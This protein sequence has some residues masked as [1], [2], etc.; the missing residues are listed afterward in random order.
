MTQISI[1]SEPVPM[2]LELGTAL[3]LGDSELFELCSRN[4]AL[5]IERTARG[6]LVVMTPAGGESS[7]RNARIVA[8]LVTWADADGS[9]VVYDSSAGFLLSDGSMRS[10]DA[11]WVRRGRLDKLSREE[12][13]RFIPLCPDFVIELRSPTDPLPELTTKMEEYRV[14]GAALGWLIDPFKH[15]VHVYRPD[16]DAEIL[17]RPATVDASPELAGFTL[18]LTQLWAE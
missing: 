4:P 13:E 16:R 5:R 12:R 1:R 8:A 17:D 9:G 11:A 18:H 14:G 10:P 7:R 15:R 6:D 3:R 2:N